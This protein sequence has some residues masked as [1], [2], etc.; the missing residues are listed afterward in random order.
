MPGRIKA[1]AM[2]K[3]MK[4]VGESL[5]GFLEEAACARR[6]PLSEDEVERLRGY[7]PTL[8]AQLD[9]LDGGDIP[10]LLLAVIEEWRANG[11]P[12]SRRNPL[13]P[14]P[15]QRRRP[16]SLEE[17]AREQAEETAHEVTRAVAKAAAPLPAPE[18]R[19]AFWCGY[20]TNIAR[21]SPFFPMNN[22]EKGRRDTLVRNLDAPAKDKARIAAS[23]YFF[24]KEKISSG[25]SGGHPLFRPQAEH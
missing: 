7:N 17:L 14:A 20:P 19:P 1:V 11:C 12:A 15:A 6:S 18:E 3:T 16:V 10:P 2:S 5:L 8:A 21:V 9:A 4:S 13:S 23:G 25:P 24:F 22:M